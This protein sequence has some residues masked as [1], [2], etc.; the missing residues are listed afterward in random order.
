MIIRPASDSGAYATG[1]PLAATAANF[2]CCKLFFP[3]SETSG[4]DF[5]DVIQG[6]TYSAPA[7]VTPTFSGGAV[8]L[9]A[10]SYTAQALVATI[11]VAT[12]NALVVLVGNMGNL[13]VSLTNGSTA[14]LNINS[15]SGSTVTDGTNTAT[16]ANATSG[17]VV[18][19]AVKLTPG[20]TGEG[21]RFSCTLAALTADVA[22]NA[23]AGDLA[24]M[25]SITTMSITNP[26]STLVIYGL[27]F[28]VFDS[29]PS[30]TLVNAAVAEM[31]ANWQANRKWLPSV[32]KGV[33]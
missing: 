31:T 21:Q 33:A 5:R 13:V 28:F 3:Y 26:A 24:T 18:G 1:G 23:L 30:A 12:K 16:L 11:P 4:R 27:A 20:T 10:G 9:S 8:T 32:L 6:S 22:V 2:P 19:N 29:A 15:I 17:S 25:P 14:G 7:S